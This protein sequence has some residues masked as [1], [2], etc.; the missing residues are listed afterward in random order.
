MRDEL[1]DLK[2]MSGG[3]IEMW[4]IYGVNELDKMK[5]TVKSFFNLTELNKY[6]ID[7]GVV[8]DPN[9]LNSMSEEDKLKRKISKYA[10]C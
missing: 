3:V 7:I 2:F 5:E 10:S 1:I 8:E 6:L 9:A 4:K